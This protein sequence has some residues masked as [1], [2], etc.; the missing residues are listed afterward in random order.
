MKHLHASRR[1][2]LLWLTV[3]LSC[4]SHSFVNAQIRLHHPEE[5]G[6]PACYQ[7]QTIDL[8]PRDEYESG[9][10]EFSAEGAIK[11]WINGVPGAS[12]M[13]AGI[14]SGRV[15]ADPSNSAF[16]Q[17]GDSAY[18]SLTC[19]YTI[20][21]SSPLSPLYPPHGGAQAQN[22]TQST[23]DVW[24][25][26]GKEKKPCPAGHTA[27]AQH[28]LVTEKGMIPLQFV[29]M[30]DEELGE[31]RIQVQY[32]KVNVASVTESRK[33][34]V[35]KKQGYAKLAELRDKAIA[36]DKALKDNKEFNSAIIKMSEKIKAVKG[37]LAKGPNQTTLQ[38]LFM[39]G[40]VQYR[41][42]LEVI[43]GTNF[44]E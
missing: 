15:C 27:P 11:Y 39:V 22:V 40:K 26:S 44:K 16:P 10:F 35:T 25:C 5:P 23:G 1:L 41:V 2:L 17:P 42:D 28:T 34:G 36:A 32:A 31:I 29:L 37:G 30:A 20:T 13:P 19:N 7:G 6:K 9:T 24:Y 38:E 14:L 43:R 4:F 12:S 21:Y 8:T 33:G 3:I 18:A